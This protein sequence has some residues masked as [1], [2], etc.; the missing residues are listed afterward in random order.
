[1]ALP[2]LNN[3][4]KYDL[5]IPST[6]KRVK[7]RPYLTKEEKILL[8]AMETKD[9]AQALNAVLD[10]IVACVDEKID[11]NSLTTFDIEYMF[12]KLR[13][14]SVGETS[15]IGIKCTE[16]DHTNKVAVDLS[17]IEVAVPKVD[18]M[19]PL[20]DEITVEMSYPHFSAMANNK[21]LTHSNSATEQT[22]E[23]IM[24]VMAAIHTNE[25]RIDLKDVSHKEIEEFIDSTTDEQIRKIRAF[26]ESIPKM[27]HD[28]SFKCESCHH[29]NT[30]TIEGMQNFF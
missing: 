6:G 8:L 22:F 4:P 7:F 14:K 21:K 12:V 1:M 19:V 16:C 9:P 30:H 27:T 15:E 18:F 25:E 23:M 3:T 13:S 24:S 11:P 5:V 2:K 10:T 29:S 26:V 20:T 28:V 17:A